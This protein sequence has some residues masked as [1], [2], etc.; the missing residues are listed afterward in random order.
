MLDMSHISSFSKSY[1]QVFNANSTAAN[2]NFSPWNKPRGCS[3]VRV[4]GLGGGGGGGA[5]AVP[6][7]SSAGGGGGASGSQFNVLFPAYVLPDILWVSVGFGGIPSGSGI[8]T[9][10]NT[11][12]SSTTAI[13]TATGGGG[14]SAAS[15]G[16]AGIAGVAGAATISGVPYIQF[17]FLGGG[18]SSNT[19]ASIAGQSGTAGSTNSNST[20]LAIPITGLVVTGGTGG[21]GVNSVVA[22]ETFAGAITANGLFFTGNQTNASSGTILDGSNGYKVPGVLFYM[23]GVGGAAYSGTPVNGGGVGGSGAI[24]CGGGGGGGTYTGGGIQS[25]GGR[26]GDGIVIITAW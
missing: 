22:T 4:F 14:G 16:T 1:I 11:T 18:I 9:A 10:I 20:A 6:G 19:N 2:S 26:G 5:G 21:A 13:I 15:G 24:G 7:T 25:K 17:C 12:P 3:F 23:G 8:S